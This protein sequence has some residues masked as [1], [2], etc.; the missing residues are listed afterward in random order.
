MSQSSRVNHHKRQAIPPLPSSARSLLVPAA[1]VVNHC[2]SSVIHAFGLISVLSVCSA[3]QSLHGKQEGAV[4]PSQFPAFGAVPVTCVHDVIVVALG[5][6]RPYCDQH[7]HDAPTH[8]PTTQA[9]PARS[10]VNAPEPDPL[11]NSRSH[12]SLG[13]HSPS[14]IAPLSPLFYTFRTPLSRRF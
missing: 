9:A 14:Y 8:S 4:A 7:R 1:K 6:L 5:W 10:T 13:T 11:I 3:S 12:P 2:P